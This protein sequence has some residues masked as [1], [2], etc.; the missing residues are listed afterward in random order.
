MCSLVAVWHKR[1]LRNRLIHR[2]R[3]AL[4][5]LGSHT[6][7]SRRLKMSPNMANGPT[8]P[9][10]QATHG[11]I[12]CCTGKQIFRSYKKSP[13]PLERPLE[14]SEYPQ[15]ESP[16]RNNFENW[17]CGQNKFRS[18][19]LL[20]R[21]PNVGRPHKNGHKIVDDFI[22]GMLGRHTMTFYRIKLTNET[23]PNPVYFRAFL[24][25]AMAINKWQKYWIFIL[26]LNTVPVCCGFL[27]LHISFDCVA[28][29]Q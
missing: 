20:C 7:P 2:T 11:N 12:V 15:R 18:V 6:A 17:V 22:R 8:G 29:Q 28:A 26:S 9:P 3:K 1:G 13:L 21:G 10:P 23:W 5:S 25:V 4:R 27:L 24:F 16:N 19:L 14:I